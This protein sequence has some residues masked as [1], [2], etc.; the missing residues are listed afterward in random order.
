MQVEVRG[1]DRGAGSEAEGERDVQIE[2]LGLEAESKE[3]SDII[4][5]VEIDFKNRI[6]TETDLYFCPV[7]R[8]YHHHPARL[9]S[10]GCCLKLADG[11]VARITDYLSIGGL[12]NP[13]MMEHDKVRDLLIDCRDS[14][15]DP[16]RPDRR[17]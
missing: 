11:L 7:C 3:M 5:R 16:M 6:V 15:S 4:K 10:C 2:L 12:F 14:L 1:D 13:E 8:S 9:C 17:V